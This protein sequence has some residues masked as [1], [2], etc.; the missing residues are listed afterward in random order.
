MAGRLT[1][2]TRARS[3]AAA[4]IWSGCPELS[5]RSA[6]RPVRDRPRA[7]AVPPPRSHRRHR[8]GALATRPAR[9]A[10]GAAQPEPV[11]GHAL[12]P[13]DLLDPGAV[14]GI[15][16]DGIDDH[17]L[18]AG[19]ERSRPRHQGLVDPARD[20][21]RRRL[22]LRAARSGR[23]RRASCGR[24]RCAGGRRRGAGR[25]PRRALGPASTCRSRRRRRPRPAAPARAPGRPAPARDRRAPPRPR[26]RGPPRPPPGPRQ[27]PG[28]WPGSPRERTER[29]A[30]ERPRRRPSWRRDSH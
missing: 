9:S 14:P 24:R 13:R 20:A 26:A 3:L 2:S 19:Q 11:E 21:A 1:G 28:P 6:R 27:S 7:G 4:A 23:R 17:R 8:P 18:A 29:A 12:R 5:S 15:E 10:A 16:A 25:A 22:R 30:G